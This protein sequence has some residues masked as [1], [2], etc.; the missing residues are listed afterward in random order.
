MIDSERLIY[1][2]K[3]YTP[4]H[5]KFICEHI[6]SLADELEYIKTLLTKDLM[7]AQNRDEFSKSHEIID[8]QETLSA[9]ISD[10]KKLIADSGFKPEE[11]S[12]EETEEQDNK[13]NTAFYDHNAEK[14]NYELYS[15]DNTVAYDIE[16]ADVTFKKLYA[17]SYNGSNYPVKT[18]KTFLST[19]CNILYEQDSSIIRAMLIESKHPGE[20]YVKLSKKKSALQRPVEIADSN[21]YIESN[22]SADDIRSYILVLLKHY[23]IPTKAVKVYFRRDYAPLHEKQ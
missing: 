22:R 20:R 1:L 14:P 8:I 18:W 6:L 23:N 3:E 9:K 13:A 2:L 11:L 7:T 19:L 17:F 5:Y 12:A 21:I 15:L 4:A 10:L 16:N